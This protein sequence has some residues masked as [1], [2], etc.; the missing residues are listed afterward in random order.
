M[1]SIYDCAPTVLATLK[2]VISC[3]MANSR[4]H[5]NTRKCPARKIEVIVQI[6]FL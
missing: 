6:S 3:T 1:F 4:L 5:L 2:K